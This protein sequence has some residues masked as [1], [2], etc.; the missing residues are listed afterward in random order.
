MWIGLFCGAYSMVG[1]DENGC[2]YDSFLRPLRAG[3][4]A[5]FVGTN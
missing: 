4:Q 5:Q 3:E 2:D 1:A